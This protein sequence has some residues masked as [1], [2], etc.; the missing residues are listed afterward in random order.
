MPNT[1]RAGDP[2][3]SGSSPVDVSGD[4]GA[5]AQSLNDRV[6]YDQGPL[7]SR[8][9]A[10]S[11]SPSVKTGYLYLQTDG[12]VP[13]L[14][15]NAGTKWVPLTQISFSARPSTGSNSL[16]AGGT[17]TKVLLATEEWDDAGWFSSSR[18]TPQVA[19]VYEFTGLIELA[20][21]LGGG[22]SLIAFLF[23]NGVLFKEL[24]RCIAQGTQVVSASGTVLASANGTSDYFELFGRQNDAAS[25]RYN[26]TSYF[27]GRLV[28]P[29]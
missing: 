28:R 29:D 18:L 24:G 17:D 20:D 25:R 22:E 3:P 14:W 13:I 11:G 5:L 8:P 6:G 1:A 23:K 12:A 7:S 15:R 4:I 19:G 2:Y 16:A 10:S 21:N 27:Q 9:P 26:S